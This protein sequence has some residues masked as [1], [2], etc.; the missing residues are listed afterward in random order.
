VIPLCPARGQFNFRHVCVSLNMMVVN[1]PH[2][3]IAN[4]K[5]KFDA[6]SRLTD[7]PALEALRQLLGELKS[8]TLQLRSS[9]PH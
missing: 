6:Q 7:Q 4:A 9:R 2:V 8:L 5:S 1:V 3:D